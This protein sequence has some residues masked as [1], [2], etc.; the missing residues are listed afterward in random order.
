ME[1]MY[2][3]DTFQTRCNKYATKSQLEQLD[4]D[5]TFIL[6]KAIRK[7]AGK[8]RTILFSTEK[9]KRL[10]AVR[11]WKGLLD[12]RQGRKIT[13]ETIEC[14]R[15]FLNLPQIQQLTNEELHKRVNHIV[16]E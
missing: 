12:Q 15:I 1:T 7:V 16:N 2:F 13:N 14:R 11:Y 3:E 5:F 9:V 6:Q 4:R 10:A 8:R